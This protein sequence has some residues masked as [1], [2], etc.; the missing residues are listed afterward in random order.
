MPTGRNPDHMTADDRRAEIASILA[1]GML[2]AIRHARRSES[3]NSNNSVETGPRRL[4]LCANAPLS[5]AARP[6]G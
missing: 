1:A 3:A 2:R 6:A 5:V 4:E